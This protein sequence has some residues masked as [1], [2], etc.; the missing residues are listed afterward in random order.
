MLE[1]I[2]MYASVQSA[3]DGSTAEVAW[4]STGADQDYDILETELELCSPNG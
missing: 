3:I 2:C 4:Q 1:A